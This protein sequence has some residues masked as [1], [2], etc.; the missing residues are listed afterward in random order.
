MQHRPDI[1][2]LNLS[3]HLHRKTF[4]F[5]CRYGQQAAHRW[6]QALNAPPNHRF[7]PYRYNSPIQ[8]IPGRP[9]AGRVL[10]QVALLL[11]HPQQFNGKQRLSFGAPE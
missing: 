2:S 4:P 11:Q 8:F 5:H 10:Y 3:Q 6:R 7:H 9:R 1:L